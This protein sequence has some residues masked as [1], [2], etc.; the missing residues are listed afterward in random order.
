MSLVK[1][2]VLIRD[3]LGKTFPNYSI[4]IIA[5]SVDGSKVPARIYTKEGMLLTEN[6]R[7]VLDADGYLSVYVDNRYPIGYRLFH[8]VSGYMLFELDYIDPDTGGTAASP[9][10]DITTPSSTTVGNIV[11]FGDDKGKVLLDTGYKI[12]RLFLLEQQ[13]ISSDYTFTASDSRKQMYRPS[14]DTV[15]RTWTI[16]RNQSVPFVI[17]T[18]IEIIN[19]ASTN[20]T[21]GIDTDTMIVADKG[22]AAS[23]IVP[24][25]SHVSA[26]KT[27]ATEWFMFGTAAMPT[28]ITTFAS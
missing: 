10:L 11:V 27:A 12:D 13:R 22:P 24:R 8:P 6:G 28:V 14:S 19:M 25:Y 15:A 18:R 5:T 20:L 7:T 1:L 3:G 21:V 2:N 26:L 4:Q 9:S 23:M 16:P 17:G